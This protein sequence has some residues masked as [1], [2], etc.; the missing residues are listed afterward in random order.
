MN[1]HGRKLAGPYKGMVDILRFNGRQYLVAAGIVLF[2]SLAA[3]TL[4]LSDAV[5]RAVWVGIALTGYWAAMSLMV[6]HWV[7]DRSGL[8][9]LDWLGSLLPAAPRRI[10]NL[11]AGVDDSTEALK[12]RF[13]RAAIVVGD[14]FDPGLMDEPSIQKARCLRG[15]T[16][17]LA[18]RH[19]AFPYPAGEFD[20]V[21]L[22]FAAHE[23]RQPQ[24]RQSLLAEA[25]RV[26]GA[27]GRLLVVE[28][29][30]DFQ[31]FAA[32]GPGFCHFHSRRTWLADFKCSGLAIE[33][34]LAKTPFVR[35]WILRLGT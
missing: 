18:I 20:L 29:L 13:P 19:D 15:T 3:A 21:V 22:M 11:H 10:L 31:N 32:F 17:D 9:G 12:K 7:Y 14:C 25:R 34:E 30:R 1:A 4:T 23:L 6:S 5:R 26:A 28:H 2:A 35:V 8:M 27:G 16:T 33:R 24:T